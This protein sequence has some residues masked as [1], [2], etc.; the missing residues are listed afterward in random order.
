MS[1]RISTM[2]L[3]NRAMRFITS[4]VGEPTLR[5]LVQDAIVQ[6][7]RELRDSVSSKPLHWLTHPY[8][9]LRTQYYAEISA[10]TQADPGV[11]TAQSS[12]DDITG[13]GFRD[14]S[15]DHQDIVVIDSIGG[16]EELNTRIYLLEYVNSTTFTL[17]TLDGLDAVATTNYTEYTSGGIVY[18]IGL[19][20]NTTLILANVSDKWDFKRVL[21]SPRFDGYPTAPIPENEVNDTTFWTDV[22]SA[23][24]PERWREWINVTESGTQAHYLFWYPAANQ[25]YNLEFIYEK[26]IADIS[27]F[28]KTTYPFHPA[29]IHDILWKGALAQLVGDNEKAKRSSDK[30]IATQ[31]EVLFAQKWTREWEDGKKRA[32]EYS[33]FLRGER[34]G[35]S[36]VRA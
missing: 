25:Q 23:R 3:V 13:H 10:I 12:N 9:G 31:L 5:A 30:V 18:C 15:T 32:R 24:R 4:D 16:M 27:V 35:L 22:S 6:A 19:V 29:E 26:D 36:G 20:L 14:N 28:T 2:D 21:P 33:K 34:G 17:K 7:D 1:T 11:I 8:D